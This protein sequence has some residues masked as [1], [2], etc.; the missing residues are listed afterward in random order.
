VIAVIGKAGAYRNAD[1]KTS[2]RINT[3]ELKPKTLKNGGSGG[4]ELPEM[5]KLK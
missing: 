5:P 4:L 3:D 1:Q 2:P